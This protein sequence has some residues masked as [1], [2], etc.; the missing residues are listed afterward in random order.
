MYAAR[1]QSNPDVTKLLLVKGAERT[2][3][4]KYGLT[5]LTLA[6]GYSENA[7]VVSALLESYNANSDEA[8]AAFAYGISNYNKPEVLQAFLDKR[9]PL[10]IPYE[11]KTPLMLAC[12]TNSN[13]EI[14]EWLLKNG[15]SK[16]QQEAATGKT[17]FDYAKEN[18]KLPHNVAY[19]SLNPNS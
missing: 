3:K 2:S 11:G 4:N 1:F 12:Q 6:S 17:A 19:W 18:K 14:I 15:A 10:N 9:V 16:Y 13:T 8:R 7:G 5:A